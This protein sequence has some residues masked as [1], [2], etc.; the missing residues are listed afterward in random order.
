M[1]NEP[2][3]QQH[4]DRRR[5]VLMRETLQPV[6]VAIIVGIG[7]SFLTTY[8]A[9]NSL[10]LKV[11]YIEKSMDTLTSLVK[12]MNQSALRIERIEIW[13]DSQIKKTDKLEL[14]LDN[15]DLRK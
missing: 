5:T 9:V 6:L 12:D 4:I 1:N 8:I 15:L 11:Q 14:R 7:S 13:Q 3:E 2:Q 10:Q